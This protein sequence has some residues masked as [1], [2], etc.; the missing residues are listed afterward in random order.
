MGAAE[1]IVAETLNETIKR[2][3]DSSKADLSILNK[4]LKRKT[5]KKKT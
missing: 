3:R 1:K 4:T 2:E 5:K